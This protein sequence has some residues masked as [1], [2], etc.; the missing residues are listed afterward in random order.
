M[1]LSHIMRYIYGWCS[2]KAIKKNVES[3]R[4]GSEAIDLLF[5]NRNEEWQTYTYMCRAVIEWKI[6]SS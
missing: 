4:L 5:R 3:S 1:R 2:A 6:S